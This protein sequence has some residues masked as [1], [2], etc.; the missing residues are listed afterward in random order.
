M[1]QWVLPGDLTPLLAHSNRPFTW[2]G[3]WPGFWGWDANG[4]I[5]PGQFF[6]D[7]DIYWQMDDRLATRD[8]DPT[9]GYLSGI[10]VKAQ[11][12]AFRELPGGVIF[13]RFRL[14]NLSVWDYQDLYSGFYFDA[15]AY[16]RQ[17]NGSM[18]GRSNDDDMMRVIPTDHLAMI[19]NL[20][21][22]SGG[23]TGLAFTGVGF[24]Q[25]PPA[26]REIDLNADGLPDVFIGQPAGATGWHWFDWYF[27]PGAW[28]YGPG[29]PF[30]G[31]GVTRVAVDKEAI[32]YKLMAGDTSSID[33]PSYRH[34]FNRTHYFHP[35]PSGF[36]NP[37][38]DSNNALLQNYPDGLDCVFILSTGPFNLNSGD[39]TEIVAVLLAADDSLT[40]RHN[41]R[42]ARNLW[43]RKYVHRKIELV[44]GNGGE[45][46]SGS[47]TLSWQIDPAYPHPVN[48]VDVWLGLG[49]DSEWRPLALDVSNSGSFSFNTADWPDGTFYRAAVVSHD[50][51]GFVSGVSDTFFTVDNPGVNV[52]PD[53]KVLQPLNADTLR[54]VVPIRWLAG[55]ADGDSISIR[56]EA[57]LGLAWSE[58]YTGSSGSGLF[59][60]DSRTLLNGENRLRVTATDVYGNSSPAEELWL[61]VDNRETLLPDSSFHHVAGVGNGRLQLHI[62][63][64][65]AVTGHQY[66]IIFSPDSAHPARI[67]DLNTGGFV[68]PWL[69][70]LNSLTSYS[71][72]GMVLKL[73]GF[74]P[75]Q[76]DSAYWKIGSPEWNITPLTQSGNPAHYDL[77]FGSA[78]TDTVYH[79]VSGA[80]L[81]PV[82]FHAYNRSF[83]PNK[84][85]CL[86]GM[87]SPPPGQFNPEDMIFLQDSIV[88]G[89]LVN[90]PVRSYRLLFDW[91]SGSTPP[92]PGDVFRFT[93][94]GYF[95]EQ[96]T[97][98]FKSP[99]WMGVDDPGGTLPPKYELF[100]NYPNPFNPATTIRYALPRAEKVKLEIF[101]ILGQR[102]KTLVNGQKPAGV[103]RVKWDGTNNAGVPVASGLYLLRFGTT[104][105]EKTKKMFLIR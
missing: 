50:G 42:M 38:F 102:V 32:Q 65:G 51:A 7:E 35:D 61:L 41:A 39:S 24:T 73:Q 30:S 86:V 19:W 60:Y 82:P 93:T 81:F 80:P 62:T 91:E 36:L 67:Q 21:D 18:A 31:D 4:Q 10:K 53:L 34:L 44:T 100:P 97:I 89:Q 5:V 77:V 25:T 55:D 33:S 92:Q 2:P 13:L 27:R 12:S 84:P 76:I 66:E 26:G 29:G 52:A 75:P 8:V 74:D 57:W 79:V 99:L 63:E 70:Y 40:L 14:I 47:G 1:L 6:S 88:A 49:Y 101:N 103:H 43:E 23:A 78:N 11:S 45:L 64:P 104:Q 90:P 20:D 3:F 54:G 105:F 59:L 9:Q 85:L 58:I 69:Y 71:F 15:D 37:R 22:N 48:T 68:S 96:D 28:D 16:H 94:I 17:K 95:W 56:I 87:D 72:D 83:F 98:Q 46:F